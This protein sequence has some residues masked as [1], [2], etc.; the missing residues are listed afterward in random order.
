MKLQKASF[1]KTKVFNFSKKV[2][3]SYHVDYTAIQ[4]D[5]HL[6]SERIIYISKWMVIILL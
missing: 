2:Y 6:Q 1:L 4:L 5:K 3:G